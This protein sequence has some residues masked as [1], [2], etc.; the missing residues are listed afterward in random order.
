MATGERAPARLFFGLVVPEPARL[1][2]AAAGRRLESAGWR[3]AP[4]DSLHITLRF[5]GDT[6]W[7][8]VPDLAAAGAA[9]ARGKGA[10]DVH[11]GRVVGLPDGRRARVAAAAVDAGAEPLGRLAEALAHRL[12]PL[13]F[14]PEGRP[15]RPHLTLARSGAKARAVPDSP[16]DVAFRVERLVLWQSRLERPHA[17]HLVVAEA[18]L[19]PAGPIV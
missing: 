12:V 11:L 18:R 16:L 9:T 4:A 8:L 17:H 2:L 7:A 14:G 3:G 15:F 19:G 13:G 6:P 5:L 10:F 1:A